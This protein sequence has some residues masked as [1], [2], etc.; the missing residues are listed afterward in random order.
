MH[1]IS[2]ITDYQLKIRNLIQYHQVQQLY[3]RNSYRNTRIIY[4]INVISNKS[5]TILIWNGFQK[6]LANDIIRWTYTK[7]IYN[8]YISYKQYI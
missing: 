3:L 5:I 1:T 4:K 2:S 6:N 7:K 8:R